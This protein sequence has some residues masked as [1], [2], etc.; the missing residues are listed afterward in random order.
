MD[1]KPIS[2]LRSAVSELNGR[3]QAPSNGNPG[4]VPPWLLEG[5][6]SYIKV[7]GANPD[8]PNTP[9]IMEQ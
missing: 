8:N 2:P 4:I 1:I 9:V 6:D 5:K 3:P 7:I